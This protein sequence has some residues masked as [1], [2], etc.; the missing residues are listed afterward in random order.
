MTKKSGFNNYIVEDKII[1]FELK[2]RDGKT[3]FGIIDLDDLNKLVDLDI[4]WYARYDKK[5]KDYY[6][7]GNLKIEKEGNEKRI[8]IAL[9]QFILDYY[10]GRKFHID[11]INQSRLD[12]RKKNLRICEVNE[13]TKNRKGKNSNN[14][15][16]H[17]NVCFYKNWYLVQ[18]QINGKNTLILKTKDYNEACKVADKSRLEYYGEFAGQN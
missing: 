3:I 13:N 2:D 9:H 17:R 7:Q 16:G 12:N 18:L 10:G 6:I 14:T 1:K 5:L 11:H 4:R 15:S 8:T